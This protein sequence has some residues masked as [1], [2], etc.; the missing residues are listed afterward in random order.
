ML[1]QQSFI[2]TIADSNDEFPIVKQIKNLTKYI[3]TESS[4]F[5]KSFY[6]IQYIDKG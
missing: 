3:P 5:V 1:S 4:K 2:F 6:V